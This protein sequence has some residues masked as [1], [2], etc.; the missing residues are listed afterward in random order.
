MDEVNL[1]KAE[2]VLKKYWGYESFREGQKMAIQSVLE[3]K[4]T[5]V[6]FPTGGGK[7][8]CYQVPSLMLDG[9]TVVLS[10][11]VALMQD[12]VEH[13]K[14]IG[15]RAT[16]INSTLPGYEV[17]QRLVNARN[18]MYK[19]LYIAPE[20]LSTNLWKVEEPNLN[21][22]L[23]AID[24]AHCISEWG[25]DFRPAYR[26]IREELSNTPE[27]TR[28][29]ALTATATPEVRKDLL[30]VLKFE[31]PA[32]ITS[33][34]KRENLHWWVTESE[35]KQKVLKKSVQKA[36]K[37]GS[38][39]VYAS[40]R[41]DCNHWADWFNKTG[42]KSEPYH[43]GLASDQ[44]KTVQHAW[45]EGSLPLVVAT[46]AFGMGIDKADCR[47]VIH[48]TMP[49]SLESYYQE[50]GRAGRDGKVSYPVLLFKKSD[51]DY[52]ENRI[53]QS[54]P[55]YETLQKVY[56]ALCDELDLAVGSEHEEPDTV[57]FSN[58][59]RRIAITE[60]RLNTALHLLQ[61]LGLL[62]LVELRE[63]RVGIKF[64]ASP[65]YLL[66]FVNNAEPKKG[67]FLD[68]LYRML[69]PQ[70]VHEFI[71]MRESVLV[72]K[73][74]VTSRQ[75]Q[76]ALN[77]FS[78]YDQILQYKWQGETHLVQIAE[79]RMKK[80]QIDHKSAYQYKDVLLKKLEYMARYAVTSECREVFL[81][82]Y[83][84]ETDCKPCGNCDNCRAK[85]KRDVSISNRDLEKIIGYLAEGDKSAREI[86]E[87]TGWTSEKLK[88]AV[89]YMVREEM[90]VVNEG[91]TE[92]YRLRIR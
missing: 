65:D 37:L 79:A 68:K 46:N 19:M 12:Q 35:N 74:E 24:E 76:K 22:K 60:G 62:H 59:A 54:Y 26:N 81:R 23:V 44:R 16:F 80:L 69:G 6:L 4:D 85:S 67:E 15:I 48:H 88:K 89:S 33:G 36:A 73:L 86:A 45:V 5:L 34:F 72:N 56:N 50:A 14:K 47:F 29:I 31:N 42:V 82:T 63:P 83:F 3:G 87:H 71:Y 9:L 28:W 38:G 77:V 90:I 21:I 17:E 39:I 51:I 84:G 18:G 8:L 13:L 57:S 27:E 10:P 92:S 41:R 61:R 58:V 40:T 49:F 2:E 7:S 75:L 1:Q 30:E 20:R 70:S 55:D 66:D 25:H 91:N 32:T 78:G 43:A 64:I 52:L 11:L 53:K